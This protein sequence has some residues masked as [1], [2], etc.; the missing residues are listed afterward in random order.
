MQERPVRIETE[1]DL[2]DRFH[3]ALADIRVLGKDVDVAKVALE[4]LV[5]PNTGCDS[6]EGAVPLGI[7]SASPSS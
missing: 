4:R 7:A 3:P 5:V 6:P 2:A 1:A